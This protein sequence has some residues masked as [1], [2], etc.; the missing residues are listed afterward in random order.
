MDLEKIDKLMNEAIN[1]DSE[2]MQNAILEQVC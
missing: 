1:K 2:L